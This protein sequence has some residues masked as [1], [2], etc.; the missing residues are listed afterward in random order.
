MN[1]VKHTHFLEGYQWYKPQNISH[2]CGKHSFID[3]SI[4]KKVVCSGSARLSGTVKFPAL[5]FVVLPYNIEHPI[6][7]HLQLSP[8]VTAIVFPEFSRYDMDLY[9]LPN[10]LTHLR[11]GN[12]FNQSLDFLP[13][14]LT[15]L[16]IG[17]GFV[18]HLDNLPENLVVLAVGKRWNQPVDNLPPTLTH[19]YLGDCFDHPV[20]NLPA[21]LTHL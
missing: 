6:D 18:K 16:E 19:L 5:S 8:Y 4:V 13:K 14:S 15:H 1:C 11:T 12:A 20:D 7:K 17:H 21:N 9:N 10:T 2:F 3:K